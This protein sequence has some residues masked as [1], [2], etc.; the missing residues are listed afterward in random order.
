ML[1]L[2]GFAFLAGIVTVLSP[3]ILPVLPVVLSGSVGGGKARPWGII[4]GFVASF[5]AF[6]LT[7]AAL[8]QAL[9]LSADV[10]RWIAAGLVIVFGLVMVVPPLKD[11]FQS[12]ASRLTARGTAVGKPKAGFWSGVVLGLSLGLVWTPCVGPI[13][14][15]V[16]SLA[17]TQ[18][19][20]AGS[21]AI[22]FAYALGTAIPLF[23]IMQGGRALLN[24]FPFFTK[25]SGG[26]QKIFGVLM[27]VTGAALLFGWD[28]Q[29]QTSLLQAFP[30]YGQGLT[31]WEDQ[32]FIRREIEKRDVQGSETPTAANP[33]EQYSIEGGQSW[34]NSEPLAM[35]SLKGKVVLVDFWTYSCINCLRTIPYLKSWDEAY[36]DKGLV[37]IGV[38]SPEFA[39]EK[40]LA[41]VQ[42]AVKDLGIR[43]PVVQ[44]NDFTIWK[45][46]A[47]RFWPA[48]YFFDRE[49][50][51][52]YTHYGEGRYKESEILIQALLGEKGPL[53]AE[54]V[55]ATKPELR[56]GTPETYLGYRRAAAFSSPEKVV[57]DASAEYSFPAALELHR[58]ALSGP[59]THE[60][61]AVKSEGPAKL[62]LRFQARR[63]YLVI[64]PP[65][66]MAPP[67][68]RLRVD[69]KPTLTPDA[70]DGLLKLGGDRLYQLFDGSSPTEGVLEVEVG[71]AGVRLFAF[72]FG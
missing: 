45:R 26:I 28:R 54:Q 35:E 60:G 51:L 63:I 6:T 27:L 64:Q 12:L 50:K 17:L 16:I 13:M 34:I 38:H 70:P 24:R 46:Y 47:N 8:V 10:L 21:F 2:I 31:S 19:L 52:R 22:T 14:A 43:Y 32:D 65:P 18:S 4:T 68:V 37:I 33:G 40:E 42:N 29:F 25:H 67:E 3:C 9:G 5:T 15:S 72:T 62:R 59:W 66:G 48:H 1:L 44:D 71:G 20:D 56:P 30:Q 61:E 11:A 39:F 41:N 57:R 69:G 53:T 7:L 58:W 36:R 49:G 23:V 55:P